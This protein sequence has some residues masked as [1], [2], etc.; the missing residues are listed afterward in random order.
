MWYDANWLVQQQSGRS[1]LVHAMT[2]YFA[3]GNINVPVGGIRDLGQVV[4]L[5]DRMARTEGKVVKNTHQHCADLQQCVEW[6]G[7]KNRTRTLL[8]VKL[9]TTNTRSNNSKANHFCVLKLSKA[10]EAFVWDSWK[11]DGG[12][13]NV[14]SVP[15]DKYDLQ[16]GFDCITF[17]LCENHGKPDVCELSD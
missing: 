6:L 2:N 7:E 5:L 9:P 13:L 10:G 14:K 1:C 17:D 16:F 15:K 4:P 12:N 8:H 3:P 11:K